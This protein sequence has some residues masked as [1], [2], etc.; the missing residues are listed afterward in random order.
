[1]AL[2]ECAAHGRTDG[3]DTMELIIL[4]IW[5]LLWIA[6]GSVVEKRLIKIEH[7]MKDGKR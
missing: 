3:G 4:I 1:M 6:H 7:M 2:L 5:F